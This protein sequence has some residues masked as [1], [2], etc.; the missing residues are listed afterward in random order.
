MMT[1]GQGGGGEE[2]GKITEGQQETLGGGWGCSIDSF[3]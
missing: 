3:S 2:A 1:Q